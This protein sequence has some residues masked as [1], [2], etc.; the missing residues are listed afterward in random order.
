MQGELTRKTFKRL[1]K[2]KIAAVNLN[3]VK[4]DVRPFIKDAQV[5]EIW[6]AD[7]FSQLADRILFSELS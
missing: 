6:S 7:Y 2:E 4:A 3:A 1:L 5:M